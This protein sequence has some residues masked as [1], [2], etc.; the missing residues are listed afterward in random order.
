TAEKVEEIVKFTEREIEL[1]KQIWEV[2]DLGNGEDRV[3]NIEALGESYEH[4]QAA[5]DLFIDS[6]Y[7]WDAVMQQ[8]ADSAE[9]AGEATEG[10][11]GPIAKAQTKPTAIWLIIDSL[12]D[13]IRVVK[14]I[15]GSG[16]NLLKVIFNSLT[17]TF[18]DHS[19]LEGI[20]TIT[21]KIADLSDKLYI[22]APRAQKLRPIFDALFTVFKVG[23]KVLI[24]IAKALGTAINLL[25]KIINKARDS[26]LVNDILKAIGNSIKAVVNG[27]EKIYTKLKETGVWD[28]FIDILKTVATWIGEKLIDGFNKFSDFA[29]TAADKA[30]E[31]F[32]KLSDKVKDFSKNSEDGASWLEK[33][34]EF[35]KEDIL[36]GSWLTKLKETIESIFGAGVDIFQNAYTK[37][38][39]FMKGLVEGFKS[40][41]R[42]DIDDIF[43]MM[44]HI[45]FTYM[46]IKWLWSTAKM[47]KGIGDMTSSIGKMF[48][49]IGLTIKKYGKKADAERFK[50]FADAIVEIVGSIA[51]M[52]IVFAGLEHYGYNAERIMDIVSGLVLTVTLIVGLIVVLKALFSKA[53]S[54][55]NSRIINLNIPQMALTLIAIGQVIATLI[56]S[57]LIMYSLVN[58][59]NYNLIVM[60]KVT[61]NI[62]LLVTI[63]TLLA[64]YMTKLNSKMTGL[65]GLALTFVSL[66]IVV[67]MLISS[68]RKVLDAV[69][70]V[71]TSAV[72]RAMKVM[73]WL[74]VPILAFGAIITAINKFG[75]NNNQLQTNPFKGITGLFISFA[76]L[77]RAGFIP[78]LRELADMHKMGEVG[79]SA[80]KDFQ[81]ITKWLLIF[82]SGITVVVG[83]LDKTVNFASSKNITGVNLLQGRQSNSDRSFSST[84]GG[85]GSFWAVAGIVAAIAGLFAA[86]GY[87]MKNMK[88]LDSESLK[89]FKQITIVLSV[90]MGVLAIIGAV[91][92][93][94]D[95]TRAGLGILLGIAA[96][97]ASV[98]A[99][100]LAAGYGFKAFE[101]ALTDLI[102]KLP[103]LLNKLVEFFRMIASD[104]GGGHH[105]G[106]VRNEIVNGV[107]DLTTLFLESVSAAIVAWST[108]LVNIVP[109]LVTNLFTTLIVALNSV[110]D[111]FNNQ[112]PELINAADRASKAFLGFCALVM[113]KVQENGKKLFKNMGNAIV[114]MIIENLTPEAQFAFRKVFGLD[115]WDDIVLTPEYWS[116]QA[117]L[118]EQAALLEK[119]AEARRKAFEAF[120]NLKNGGSAVATE[121]ID[122]DE[123]RIADTVKKYVDNI[124]GTFKNADFSSIKNVFGNKLSS[125]FSSDELTDMVSNGQFIDINNMMGDGFNIESMESMW[126]DLDLTTEDGVN[127]LNQRMENF[128]NESDASWD[129]YSSGFDEY[130]ENMM[131]NAGEGIN[132]RM[133]FVTDITHDAMEAAVNEIGQFREEFYNGGIY[134][135]QGFAF[136]LADA[137]SSDLIIKSAADMVLAAK[138][139]VEVTGKISSPSK[140]FMQLGKYITM[141][142]ANGIYDSVSLATESANEVGEATILSMRETIRQASLE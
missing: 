39:E 125:M 67:S 61:L 118:E 89:Q 85:G 134:C 17:G 104:S 95:Q 50:T 117:E 132:E 37:T 23:A 1:A 102:D 90:L 115:D 41:D 15:A 62:G 97:I 16:S 73:T 48:Q 139:G 31:V 128:F 83:L 18:G 10:F 136:G 74:T 78:L 57:V 76:I 36:S 116:K 12:Y 129:L 59:N 94:V 92:G 47:N 79:Q 60:T 130:G 66:G 13:V 124:G 126:S 54:Y 22:S 84:S 105:R 14:N 42:K 9:Q 52:M 112:G 5:V 3:R 77:M 51:V 98:A 127:A 135:G 43:S 4:V 38:S 68:F 64:Y 55:S 106:N 82:I 44:S 8:A 69:K 35:F 75:N 99:T 26:K 119:N 28:K 71:K 86:I 56:K 81:S 33:I 114:G 27:I 65:S 142:F 111:E 24:G 123:D 140:V 11:I 6:G 21:G 29:G 45:I 93:Q 49:S 80:I 96:V 87:T 131:D 133:T 101:E 72:E 25:A 100:F 63:F 113:L 40:I 110:A 20:N 7:T 46:S 109:E 137:K 103:N 121:F 138:H 2:G 122:I 91:V 120:E 53:A 32:G 70:D 34:K 58:S 88:G 19:I 141:C 30:I 107:A 108:G